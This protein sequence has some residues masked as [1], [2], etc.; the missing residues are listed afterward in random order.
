MYPISHIRDIF[1][2]ASGRI[3]VQ[4]HHVMK[5]DPV[6]LAIEIIPVIPPQLTGRATDPRRATRS[7]PGHGPAGTIAGIFSDIMALAR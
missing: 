4:E 5:E 3:Q 6:L 2:G 1:G 7:E